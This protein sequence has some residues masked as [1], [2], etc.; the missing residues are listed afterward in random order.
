VILRSLL[1]K[2][3]RPLADPCR[4]LTRHTYTARTF[5]DLKLALGWDKDPILEGD[6]LHAYLNELDLNKRPLRDAQIVGGACANTTGK[7]LLEIGTSFGHTTALMAKNAPEATVH[8]VNIPPEEIAEG[9]KAV[10]FAPSR[11]EIGRYYRELGLQNVNQ[12]YA[13]TARWTPDFGPIDVAFIDGCHDAKFVYNDTRIVLQQ[14]RPGSIIMWHD[15]C[16]PLVP[17][18]DWHHQ[19]RMGVQMLYA[20][21]L[22]RGNIIHLQDSW[23]GLYRVTERDKWGYG[24]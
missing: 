23:V 19:V 5:E 17:V 1:W 6:H 10:T 22:I 14:C 11:D 7:I 3:L 15:F 18:L 12:I 20:K 16:P 4:R 2:L 21:R 24:R 13:N 8:T 9:G